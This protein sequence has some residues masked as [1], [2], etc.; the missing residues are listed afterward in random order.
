[1]LGGGGGGVLYFNCLPDVMWLLA[2]GI[3]TSW[4]RG[5]VCWTILFAIESSKIQ[6]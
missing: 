1:M 4:C 3:A 5:L 2:F 6:Q